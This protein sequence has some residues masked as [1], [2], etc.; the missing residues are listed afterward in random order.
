MAEV[1]AARTD[2]ES[3][4]HSLVEVVEFAFDAVK[5]LAVSGDHGTRQ[6]LVMIESIA[7]FDATL[8]P[9]LHDVIESVRQHAVSTLQLAAALTDAE[10]STA[11]DV[12][13]RLTSSETAMASAPVPTSVV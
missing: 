13:R 2:L 7:E 10:D 9:V 1:V 4:S 12:G 6:G 8:V 3:L 11:G 5:C